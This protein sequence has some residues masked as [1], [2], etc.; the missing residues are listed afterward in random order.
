M[1]CVEIWNSEYGIGTSGGNRG[2]FVKFCEDSLVWLLPK[3]TA[4]FLWAPYNLE[5][6]L[7][8]YLRFQN[9]TDPFW[10]FVELVKQNNSIDVMN[11]ALDMI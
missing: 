7:T 6:Y 1:Q 2:Y 5:Q 8:L 4:S 3:E 10:A 11:E 9:Q